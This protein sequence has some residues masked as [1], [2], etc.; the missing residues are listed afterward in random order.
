MRGRKTDPTKIKMGQTRAAKPK[1]TNA[2]V[3][4]KALAEAAAKPDGPVADLL[5]TVEANRPKRRLT[6]KD[7]HPP[8]GRTDSSNPS[9]FLL[10]LDLSPHITPAQ[11]LV[12]ERIGRTGFTAQTAAEFWMFQHVELQRLYAS[13]DLEAR[14]YIKALGVLGT[15]AAR[16]AE[17]GVRTGDAAGPTTVQFTMNVISAQVGAAYQSDPP[18]EFGDAIEVG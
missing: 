7:T 4:R 1:K 3:M 15:A 18:G 6:T 12:I 14:D 5:A 10:A 2:K 13:G 17:I 9:V 8:F 11:R 16:L